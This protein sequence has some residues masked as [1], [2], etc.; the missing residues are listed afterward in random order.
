M[1]REMAVFVN[2]NGETASIYHQGIIKIYQRKQ[3]QW[4]LLKERDFYLGENNTI[5]DI[6][7]KMKQVIDFLEECKTFVGL[8]VTGVPYF[9]LEKA[10][11]SVWEYQGRPRDFLDD[12]LRME[13]EEQH[14]KQ[15]QSFI[16][17][18]PQVIENGCYRVSIK[19]IQQN[20]YGLTS[21]QVLLPIINKGEYEKLEIICNHIPPWLETQFALGILS[22]DISKDK[23]EIT[24]T[25]HKQ[26]KSDN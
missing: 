13:E 21:K 11:C 19:E 5:K 24:V 6:R 3:G 14:Q 20:N 9:E 26:L 25:I 8:T 15:S 10:R 7:I 2:D 23:D 16:S 1:P 4:S 12:I 18:L 17:I 22:A